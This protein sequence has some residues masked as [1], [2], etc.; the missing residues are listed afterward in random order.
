LTESLLQADFEIGHFLREHVIPRAVLYFTGQ[1]IDEDDGDVS[2]IFNDDEARTISF[3][4]FCVNDI[5]ASNCM[6]I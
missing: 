5:I 1:A 6:L 3:R 4:M 2:I